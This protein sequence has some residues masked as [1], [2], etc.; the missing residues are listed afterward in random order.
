MNRVI[1]IGRL[2]KD[3]ELNF[4]AG[5]G[6]AVCRFNLAVNRPFKKD[7]TDFISCVAFGKR[8]EAIAQYS[9]KG[10]QLAVVG[11]LKTG[12][13]TANDGSKRYTNDVIV[14]NFEF[15]GSNKNNNKNTESTDS[16]YDNMQPADDSDMPF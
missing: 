1:L 9:L 10:S 13:Y 14:D 11:Y 6:N 3:P 5:S 15:L 4:S 16:Y 8:A 7:E 2:T 12:S